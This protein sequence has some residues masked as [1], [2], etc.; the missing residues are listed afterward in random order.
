VISFDHKTFGWKVAGRCMHASVGD[1]AQPDGNTCVGGLRIRCQ[2]G[3]PAGRNERHPEAA[4]QITDKALNFAFR[5]GAIGQAQTRHRTGMAGI[6]EEMGMKPVHA[7]AIRAPLQD[8]RLHVVVKDFA[9]HTA[10]GV[11]SPLVAVEVSSFSSAQNRTI[12]AR[13]QPSVAMNTFSW[14][15]PLPT[16]AQSACIWRPG[17]VSKRTTGSGFG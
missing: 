14:P 4:L 6:V 5:L 3:L 12:V 9:R 17:S 16:V 1:I 15:L 13:L 11:E 7:A 10:Q 2:A 8:D